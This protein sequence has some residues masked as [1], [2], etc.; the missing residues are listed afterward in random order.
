[1][2]FKR[3]LV[4]FLVAA[5]FFLMLTLGANLVEHFLIRKSDR[6]IQLPLTGKEALLAGRNSPHSEETVTPGSHKDYYENGLLREIFYIKDGRLDGIHRVFD[7]DGML[8]LEEV[9]EGGKLQGWKKSYRAG[10]SLRK[11]FYYEHGQK[12][13][14]GRAYYADKKLAMTESYRKGVL[15]GLRTSY[16]PQGNRRS[17]TLFEKGRS[18]SRK[19]YYPN[20]L[21]WFHETFDQNTDEKTARFYYETGELLA[22]A[23]YRG[24]RPVMLKRYSREG[25][26]TLET[27]Q[28]KEISELEDFFGIIF[29][30]TAS[31]QLNPSR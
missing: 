8:L 20:G 3:L 6:K 30:K 13:G 31:A 29:D 23:T 21:L 7:P 11:E 26:L 15:H 9:Y 5:I 24:D 28:P 19:K 1:M 4:F 22:Q 14:A 25:E 17:Q 18:V 12:E 27:D 2:I 10:G 16:Y